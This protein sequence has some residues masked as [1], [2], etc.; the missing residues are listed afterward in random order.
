M[1]QKA[2]GVYALKSRLR[3]CLT[4]T[5]IQNRVEDIYPLIRFLRIKPFSEWRHFHTTFVV[6][7]KKGSECKGTDQKFQTLLKAML[8]RRR[9]D[10][11]IDNVRIVPDL[12]Q[13]TIVI[14]HAVF[15]EQQK[16][17]YYA[18]ESGT[19]LKVRKYRAEGSL[20]KNMGNMLVM[21]LRL[22]QGCLH[23]RLIKEIKIVEETALVSL[24]CFPA[25]HCGESVPSQ[26]R[27][28]D[29]GELQRDLAK[30]SK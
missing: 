9:K 11:E 15:N 18:L 16:E 12:P 26:K 8:L 28:R 20:G 2:R 7:F 13:K 22:R 24:G 1:T 19:I 10:S 4:G 25:A 27:K 5:P 3:W 29:D 17:F 30:R 23:P 14:V 6:G 21:L